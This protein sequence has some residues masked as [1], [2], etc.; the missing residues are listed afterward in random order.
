MSIKI[1]VPKGKFI[2]N[3]IENFEHTKDQ[4][5]IELIYS[6]EM[7]IPNLMLNNDVD[8]ALM[9]PLNYGKILEISP[10]K[11]ISSTCIAAEG[12]SKLA[13]IIF[14]DNLT[15]IENIAVTEKNSFLAIATKIIYDE[16]YDFNIK[17]IDQ[18]NS[19]S[20]ELNT[21]DAVLSYEKDI[22]ETGTMDLTEEWT[23]YF[24]IALPIAFWVVPDKSN[25]EQMIQITRQLIKKDINDPEVINEQ[26]KSNETSYERQ[27]IIHWH[28]YSELEKAIDDTLELLYQLNYLNLLS[29]S[30]IG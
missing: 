20:K 30:H 29:D 6:K 13:T 1:A 27:G 28:F 24:G 5:N 12:Y 21:Y 22:K 11:I 17:L 2:N 9:N 26:Y 25:I 19:K 7:D 14:G 8:L 15:K 10:Y 4:Y 3:L 16:K 18:D 23:D